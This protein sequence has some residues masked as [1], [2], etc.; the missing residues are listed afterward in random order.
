MIEQFDTKTLRRAEDI[1][2]HVSARMRERRIFLGLSR[3]Q[4]AAL[5][6]VTLQQTYK[7]ER[8]LIALPRGA[9]TELLRRSTST[10]V[11]FSREWAWTMH[12]GRHSSSG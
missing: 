12:P 8:G 6:G 5:I 2:R 11:T 7:Y 3:R 4:M 1:D 9:C 10:L